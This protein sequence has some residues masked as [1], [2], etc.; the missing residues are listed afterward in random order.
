MT[1]FDGQPLSETLCVEQVMAWC[2]RV[3][4]TRTDPQQHLGRWTWSGVDVFHAN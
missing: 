2:K 4:L 3:R 1:H